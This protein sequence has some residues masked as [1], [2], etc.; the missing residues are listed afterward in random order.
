MLENFLGWAFIAMGLGTLTEGYHAFR[1]RTE[2]LEQP[3]RYWWVAGTLW[4]LGLVLIKLG[5]SVK[6][7]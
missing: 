2:G 3:I 7:A 5:L 1:Q 4:A 6:G